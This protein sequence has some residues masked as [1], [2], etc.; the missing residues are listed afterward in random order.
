MLATLLTRQLVL[1]GFVS[2]LVIGLLALGIVLVYRATRVINFAVGNM[3]LI[4]AGLLVLMTVQYDVPYWI[5]VPA[6]LAVGTL[7]GALV[8]VTVIRRLF[9]APRVIVLVATIGIAQL[10]LAIV[11]AYPDIDVPGARF[12]QPI[13]SDHELAS[14]RITG[15]QLAI[16]I[17]VPLV[18]IL[19]AWFLTHTTLGKTV[20]ASAENIDLARLNGINPKMV[21][22]FVWAAAGALAT[23][24]LSLM[25]GLTGS[26]SDLATL[27]PSTLVRA[28]A[29]AV[30]GGMVSFP[31]AF[32]AGIA[33]GVVEAVVRF[34]YLGQPGLM[35]F[36]LLI[37]VLI[38][39]YFQSPRASPRPR[40]FRSFRNGDRFQIGCERCG[41]FATWI[42]APSRC[43]SSPR[44]RF[45]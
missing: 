21:S 8:Q 43:C 39:V 38:A 1:D 15:A 44:S 3:G 36:L 26:A 32:M 18:A 10:S 22:M 28:L 19:L 31:R 12:P 29:A 20:K 2:G 6:A 9:D 5:A 4:G 40:P 14:M 37:A 13:G 45:R 7:Y 42:G 11:T 34:N 16:M 24:S 35:D 41:G 25:A 33:I 30:I 17:V 23:L 27:G